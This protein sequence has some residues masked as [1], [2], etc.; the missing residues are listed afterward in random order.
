MFL[1][2]IYNLLFFKFETEKRNDRSIS[3]SNLTTIDYNLIKENSNSENIF[4]I[5]LDGMI[6]LDYAKKLNMIKS[7]QE[8]IKDLKN[9]DFYIKKIFFL[10]TIHHI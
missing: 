9:K 5:V 2:L 3:F 10:T 6:N 1:F 8:I 4:L 7:K